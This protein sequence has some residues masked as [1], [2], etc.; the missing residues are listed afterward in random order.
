[1]FLKKYHSNLSWLASAVGAA[2][3][4]DRY[5]AVVLWRSVLESRL[6]MVIV[7]VWGQAEVQISISNQ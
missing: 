4:L 5:I 7:I 6:V 2:S 1:M 3:R